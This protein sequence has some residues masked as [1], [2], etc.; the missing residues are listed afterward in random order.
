M[1]VYAGIIATAQHLA[2]SREV[3]LTYNK[4]HSL[5]KLGPDHWIIGYNSG[6]GGLLSGGYTTKYLTKIE[7]N[8]E[9]IT[10]L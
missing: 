4:S 8:F 7:N 1:N 3:L 9:K 2:Y 10:E 5:G 6:M